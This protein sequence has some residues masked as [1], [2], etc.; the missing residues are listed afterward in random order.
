MSYQTKNNRLPLWRILLLGV[1]VIIPVGVS[2]LACRLFSPGTAGQPGLLAS[3]IP[4]ALGVHSGEYPTAISSRAGHIGP[5]P[6]GKLLSI[7]PPGGLGEE[8]RDLALDGQGRLWVAT[9]IGLGIWDGEQWTIYNAATSL[10]PHD[11][12]RAVVTLD[13][14]IMWIGTAAGIA[15]IDD[16]DWTVFTHE[17]SDLSSPVINDLAFDKD[18]TLWAA[19]SFGGVARYDGERWTYYDKHNSGLLGLSVT[20]LAIGPDGRIWMVDGF[21][22]G[23]SMFDGQEW[24][25]YTQENSGLLNNWVEQVTVDNAGRV[26][27]ISGSELSVL[28]GETWNPFDLAPMYEE[29]FSPHCLAQRADGQAWVAGVRPDGINVYRFTVFELALGQVQEYLIPPI[30]VSEEGSI[31]PPAVFLDAEGNPVTEIEEFAVPAPQT[32]LLDDD[33]VW[34]GTSYGLFRLYDDGRA[35]P[36]PLPNPQPPR[37]HPHQPTGNPVVEF[38]QVYEFHPDY[39][40]ITAVGTV[41]V[42]N[43]Y[44][45]VPWIVCDWSSGPDL[46]NPHDVTEFVVSENIEICEGNDLACSFRPVTPPATGERFTYWM[47]EVVHRLPHLHTPYPIKSEQEFH[48]GLSASQP[49]NDEHWMRI[50]AFPLSA[51]ITEVHGTPPTAEVIIEDWRFFVYDM[52]E[53]PKPHINFVLHNDALALPVEA[54]LEAAGWQV[55]ESADE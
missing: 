50:L 30:S 12:V 53:S 20:E 39:I 5:L 1:L 37:K 26:W 9:H 44:E 46:Y 55:G 47:S 25:H 27:F 28:A 34:L 42:W 38:L 54:Y 17:N 36:V 3:P 16:G 14:K 40:R 33:G 8:I 18:G 6:A 24:T 2:S 22:D 35:E 43:D 48:F 21:G 23:V 7:L 15:R 41:E 10:L 32:L 4:T 45:P 51:D 49:E 29:Y 11:D 52:S 31:F 19:T 13:G